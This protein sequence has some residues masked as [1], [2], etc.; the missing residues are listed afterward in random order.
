[1]AKA[2]EEIQRK[3]RSEGGTSSLILQDAFAQGKVKT[4]VPAPKFSKES[5]DGLKLALLELG[6]ALKT[7]NL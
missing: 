4:D 1:L 2:L 5:L 3:P 6:K 7:V